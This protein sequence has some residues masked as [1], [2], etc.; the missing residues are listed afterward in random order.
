M[1]KYIVTTDDVITLLGLSSSKEDLVNS[2][3]PLVNAEILKYIKIHS[4]FTGVYVSSELVISSNTV[5]ADASIDFNDYFYAE[6][7]ITF[8]GSDRNDNKVYGIESIADNVL[9]LSDDLKDENSEESINIYGV[10]YPEELKLIFVDLIKFSMDKDR[11]KTSVS[12]A[13]Y[14]VS[15]SSSDWPE[16]I[17]RRLNMHRKL[18]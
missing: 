10:E 14:S 17:T 7:L 15:Y 4:V 6:D 5:T 11:D 8:K 2:L 1:A 16:S 12:L 9:T 3:I 18:F 13:D